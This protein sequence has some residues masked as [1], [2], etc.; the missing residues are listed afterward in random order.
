MSNVEHYAV[1]LRT[2][3][4]QGPLTLHDRLDRARITAGGSTHP[5]SGGM[6]ETAENLRRM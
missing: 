4:R 5:V 3:F 2:G 1:G 6:I